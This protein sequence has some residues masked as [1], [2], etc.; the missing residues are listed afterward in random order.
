MASGNFSS[1][2]VLDYSQTSSPTLRP[3]FIKE[4]QH[5]LIN[6]G[7][8]YLSNV[9]VETGA[10]VAYIPRLFALPQE[11]KDKISMLNSKHFLG[12]NKLGA[13]FTKGRNDWREQF[14]IAT[15]HVC[16]AVEGRGDPDYW[17]LWG[18]SQVGSIHK[19]HPQRCIANL[20]PSPQH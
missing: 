4:L 5:A 1:V 13:E 18:P 8:L 11:A 16:R 15:P 19:L 17:S 6:V 7:F 20:Y 3:Q 2:P 9:P 14:D 12:Y 10:L